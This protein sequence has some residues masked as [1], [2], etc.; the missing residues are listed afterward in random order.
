M[1]P[2]QSE[3]D[4]RTPGEPPEAVGLRRRLYII[5][6]EADTPAGKA[7]DL[8]LL[9]AI[10]TG[11][12]VL[13]LE[14]VPSIAAEHGGLLKAIEW[15]LTGLFSVEYVLRLL[16]TPTPARYARSFFGVV[17]VLSI[18]PTYLS[19]FVSGTHVLTVVRA[20]RLLRIFRILKLRRFVR[21]AQ[22]LGVALQ[23]S[24]RK[25]TVFI[26]SVLTMVVILGAVMYLVE[27][28]DQRFTSIPESMYWAIVTMTTVGYGDVVPQTVSGNLNASVVMIMGYGV[29]AV[30]TG[31]VSA[32]IAAAS[33]ADRR[34]T[35]SRVCRGCAR[36]A[37]DVDARF[38]KYCAAEL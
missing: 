5:I 21:E 12:C 6:F 2:P 33:K 3:L 37:H 29:I 22:T 36:D 28:D 8:A 30:P 24:L 35:E 15:V 10:A 17:D 13:L 4:D 27:G 25:I 16:S 7:F 34:S 1:K 9:V 19:L 23:A 11:V 20:L 14:S 26:G 32:E 38:C 31:I 18:L